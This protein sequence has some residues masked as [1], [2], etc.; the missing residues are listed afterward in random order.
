M[1]GGS[2]TYRRALE[3]LKDLFAPVFG[4]AV[5]VYGC[6][7]AERICEDDKGFFS[8]VEH[9][10]EEGQALMTTLPLGRT[11]CATLV[12]AQGATPHDGTQVDPDGWPP[13]LCLSFVAGDAR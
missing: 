3:E 6:P 8:A 2:D 5:E 11:G 7:L 10:F 12:T 13:A 4:P 1:R 9:R